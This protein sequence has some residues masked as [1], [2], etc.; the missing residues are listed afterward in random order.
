[1]AQQQFDDTEITHI[2]RLLADA[3][4]DLRVFLDPDNGSCNVPPEVRE[5]AREYLSTWVL[6]QIE[7][8]DEAIERRV[9][10]NEAA[11][12]VKAEKRRQSRLNIVR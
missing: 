1:M 9:N 6:P 7:Q 12:E 5:V 10:R 11:R 3:R 2:R 4:N 8:A